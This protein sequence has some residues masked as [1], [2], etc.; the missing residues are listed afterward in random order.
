MRLRRFAQKSSPA[1]PH[2]GDLPSRAAAA[3][4]QDGGRWWDLVAMVSDG[5]SDSVSK[6]SRTS[7]AVKCSITRCASKATEQRRLAMATPLSLYC[8][9]LR[10]LRAW[11]CCNAWWWM[12]ESV[13]LRTRGSPAHS[14][15]A[16]LHLGCESDEPKPPL[17]CLSRGPVKRAKEAVEAT[18]Y[19]YSPR[20]AQAKPAAG[21]SK[22]SVQSLSRALRLR[23]KMSSRS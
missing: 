5:T 4:I 11:F 9:L 3:S 6:E 7:Q 20:G 16:H 14:T 8:L 17:S 10:F 15:P 2:K 13:K 19:S 18:G 12:S 23:S 1:R 22:P 21:S